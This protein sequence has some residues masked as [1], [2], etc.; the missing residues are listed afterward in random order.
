MENLSFL[1][2]SISMKHAHSAFAF[3]PGRDAN[4]A[5]GVAGE[6]RGGGIPRPGRLTPPNT[7]PERRTPLKGFAIQYGSCTPKPAVI[8][9]SAGPSKPFPLSPTVG[10]RKMGDRDSEIISPAL[11][12]LAALS[13]EVSVS[14][15]FILRYDSGCLSSLEHRPLLPQMVIQQ[16]GIVLSAQRRILGGLIET[17]T[18]RGRCDEI[19]FRSPG[20]WWATSSRKHQRTPE[21][22]CFCSKHTCLS[23]R[24][25]QF[26]D[27]S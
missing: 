9:E 26:N 8:I 13:G 14:L 5:A 23:K 21:A 6:P 24:E 11:K 19:G 15:G 2:A 25:A 10:G 20:Q 22:L 16:R 7:S 1:A 27:S 3:D 18:E 4:R 17:R 12:V